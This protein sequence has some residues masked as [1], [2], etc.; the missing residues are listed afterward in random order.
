MCPDAHRFS[1]LRTFVKLKTEVSGLLPQPELCVVCLT[2]AKFFTALRIPAP[3]FSRPFRKTIRDG[4]AN[5]HIRHLRF[6]TR[7]SFGPAGAWTF[8][9][10]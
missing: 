1:A 7:T 10:A 9:R 4:S 6:E 8:D 3:T 2:D 5:T